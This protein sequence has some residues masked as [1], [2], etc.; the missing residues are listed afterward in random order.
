MERNDGEKYEPT[1]V[2]KF[3]RFMSLES[4]GEDFED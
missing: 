2:K 1:I 4:L 3:R